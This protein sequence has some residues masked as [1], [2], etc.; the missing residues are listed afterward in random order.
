MSISPQN[1]AQSTATTIAFPSASQ[2]LLISYS[3]HLSQW[4]RALSAL[5]EE[6]SSP[7]PPPSPS[8]KLRSDKLKLDIEKSVLHGRYVGDICSTRSLRPGYTT[9]TQPIRHAVTEV[10][11]LEQQSTP[12]ILAETEDEWFRW[13]RKMSEQRSAQ[14][15]RRDRE[16]LVPPREC[17]QSSHENV[18]NRNTGMEDSSLAPISLIDSKSRSRKDD[19]QLDFPVVKRTAN[20]KLDKLKERVPSA[21][22]ELP[23]PAMIELLPSSKIDGQGQVT[24][25]QTNGTNIV[26]TGDDRVAIN[27]TSPTSNAATFPNNQELAQMTSSEHLPHLADISVCICICLGNY[28]AC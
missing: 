16:T 28:A 25:H 13:E 22:L 24:T 26:S 4:H 10:F 1:E 18:E 14:A 6:L 27:A 7:S 20:V 8:S 5:P 23:S 19:G 17:S 9:T 15:S 11:S 2:S 12:W 21:R 3:T